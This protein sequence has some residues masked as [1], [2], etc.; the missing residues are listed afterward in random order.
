[1]AKRWLEL[2]DSERKI[3][4]EPEGTTSNFGTLEALERAWIELVER[5]PHEASRWH[6]LRRPGAA[7]SWATRVSISALQFAGSR[8]SLQVAYHYA[9]PQHSWQYGKSGSF[10]TPQVVC[11]NLRVVEK[12]WSCQAWWLEWLR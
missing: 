2:I 6:S 7:K 3:C 10:P 11:K 8:R 4:G 9:K 12:K 1:M 5:M